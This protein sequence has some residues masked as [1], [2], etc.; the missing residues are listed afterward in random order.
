V[1][2]FGIGVMRERIRKKIVSRIDWKMRIQLSRGVNVDLAQVIASFHITIKQLI[3][4]AISANVQVPHH[5][6]QSLH[7]FTNVSSLVVQYNDGRWR[8]HYGKVID[9]P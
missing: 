1:C 7:W 3:T 5:I 4:I 8:T 2:A 9:P 6:P